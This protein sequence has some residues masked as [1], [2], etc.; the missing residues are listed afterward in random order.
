MHNFETA[1]SEKNS[2]IFV[3]NICNKF[4]L[5][6]SN[7]G[8]DVSICLECGQKD[9]CNRARVLKLWLS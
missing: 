7:V 3:V 1:K 5:L 2:S 8:G 6:M 4:K 9:G